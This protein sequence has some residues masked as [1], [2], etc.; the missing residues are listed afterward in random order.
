MEL[1]SDQLKAQLGRSQV[2]KPRV[3]RCVI[4]PYGC[5]L[6]SQVDEQAIE[7]LSS[8]FYTIRRS[9]SDTLHNS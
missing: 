7:Q 3:G 9:D 6:S 5:L 4:C 8:F 1:Y 2:A